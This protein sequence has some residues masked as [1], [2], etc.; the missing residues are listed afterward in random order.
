MNP[1]SPLR[2]A[3]A[4]LNQTPLDWVGNRQR[5]V[6]ALEQARQ[7][8]VSILGLPELCITGYGCED[9]FLAHYVP[10]MAFASLLEILPHTQGLVVTLGLPVLIAPDVYNAVA[11]VVDG[12]LY[13]L[14]FKQ[15]L[16]NRN[17]Y[18]EPRWFT[19]WSK[20]RAITFQHGSLSVPAGDLIFDV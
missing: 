17:L 16:A 12:K 6:Q 9:T 3:G 11:L 13:G 15:F 20:G 4:A 8:G 5:I 2:V 7:Q 14:V 18:Y 1:L 19:P 10:A